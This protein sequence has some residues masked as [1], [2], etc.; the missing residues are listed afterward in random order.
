MLGLF[1]LLRQNPKFGL[2]DMVGNAWEWTQDCY[3][4]YAGV[5]TDGRAW[6]PVDKVGVC[7]RV[8]RGGSWISDSWNL[9]PAV[10][11]FS[12]PVVRVGNAG[13]RLARTLFTP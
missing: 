1:S 4:S 7:A 8:L 3:A 12:A 2:Y 6:E 5:H 9:R 11:N 13:F 10:R